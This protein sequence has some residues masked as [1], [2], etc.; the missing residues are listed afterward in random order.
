[1]SSET[2]TK[3]EEAAAPTSPSPAKDEKAAKDENVPKDQLD[4]SG[5]SA[6]GS[7]LREPEFNVE[8][9]LADLQADP[10]NPLFSVKSFEQLELYVSSGN[11][12]MLARMAVWP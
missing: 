9:K 2:P 5:E 1:M 8:V 10:N 6:N 4:G 12:I 3:A 11:R 7:A